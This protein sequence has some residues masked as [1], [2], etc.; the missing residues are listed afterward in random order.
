MLSPWPSSWRSRSACAAASRSTRRRAGDVVVET[1]GAASAP[2]P[3]A[4]CTPAACPP[5]PAW[6]IRWFPATRPSGASSRPARKLGIDDRR[7]GVRAR[8]RCFGDS[9]RPVWRRG[10][11]ARRS[12]ARVVPCPPRSARKRCCW[13]SPRPPARAR[14]LGDGRR[15]PDRRPRRAR[16]T[17]GA[18]RA[19]PRAASRRWSGRPTAIASGGA[20]ATRSRLRTRTTA[21]DYR[22]IYDVS[23][24]AAILDPLVRGSRRAARS[25]SPASTSALSFAFPPAFMREARIRVAAQWRDGD[26]AAVVRL[27]ET[28]R[29]SLDGLITHRRPRP[30]RPRPTRPRSTIP[31][32]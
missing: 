7:A 31:P 14:R 20:A 30:R 9:A 10:L 23:G 15:R 11:A 18:P 8:R 3:N 29:L 26:L 13:R 25:C 5:F 17:A 22:T 21:R 6:A 4:C 24:D 2:A 28:G 32:A 12:G 16:P 19:S 27:V 1:P